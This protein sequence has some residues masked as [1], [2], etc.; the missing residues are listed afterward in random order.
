MSDD[1]IDQVATQSVEDMILGKLARLDGASEGE[2][3]APV[4]AA[5]PDLFDLEWQGETFQ[6]PAKLKDA[7]MQHKDYTQKTQELADQRRVLEQARSIAE[8]RQAQS[9][10]SESVAPEQ[11]ELNLIEAYL[12]EAGKTNWTNMTTDQILRQKIELDQIKERRSDL[13]RSIGEKHAKFQT[14]MQARI[15]EL[16]GKSREIASK[17]IPD[18]SEETDKAMRAFAVSQGLTESDV[19]N[20]FLDPRSRLIVWKAMQFERV[21]AGTVAATD[22]ADK[23]LKVG[24][25]TQRMPPEVVNKLNFGKAINAAKKTGN[26]GKVAEVIE[27]RLSGMFARK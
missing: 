19:D 2:G 21:K 17:S 18:F 3:E 15:A 16:K 25:A 5:A 11:R 27:T 23:L 13:Q 4:Q 20:V 1:V 7:F 22:K 12:A 8:Q 24:A 9:A 10:F 6:V 14:D 26:S